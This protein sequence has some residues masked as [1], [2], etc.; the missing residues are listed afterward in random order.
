MKNKAKTTTLKATKP[1]WGKALALCLSLAG[2]AVSYQFGRMSLEPAKPVFLVDKVRSRIIDSNRVSGTPLEIR[3]KDGNTILG[4]VTSVRFYFWNAGR[5]SIKPDGILEPLI[6]SLD[7]PNCKILDHKILKV[8]RNLTKSLLSTHPSD[9]NRT[10]SISFTILE[11]NDGFTGQIIYKGNPTSAVQMF[12]TVQDAGPIRTD[13]EVRGSSFRQHYGMWLTALLMVSIFMGGYLWLTK[14]ED[15]IG[16]FF[17]KHTGSRRVAFWGN[18]EPIPLGLIS[19]MTPEARR[20]A[21][22]DYG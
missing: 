3:D 20:C 9:P 6:V 11:K 10:L 16:A 8:S 17:Y 2:I 14:R 12:G 21:A 1:Y 13:S 7:D 5:K 18:L 4:D 19:P 15:K 22:G